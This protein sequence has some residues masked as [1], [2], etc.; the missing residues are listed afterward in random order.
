MPHDIFI[1][2]C[3]R[4]H[5]AVKPIKEELEAQGFSCWMDLEGI[6]SGAAEFSQHI[7]DAIDASAT[8]FV[9]FKIQGK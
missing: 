5:T 6:E 7:I 3:R 8:H 2:Y 9:E 1:S 4:D